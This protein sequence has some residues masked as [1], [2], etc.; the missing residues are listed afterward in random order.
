MFLNASVN[1]GT[2]PWSN[3]KEKYVQF[4]FIPTL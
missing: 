4:Y 2:R 1:V 3:F